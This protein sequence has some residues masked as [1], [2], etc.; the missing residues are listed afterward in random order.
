MKLRAK[1]SSII[2]FLVIV[3]GFL[4]V[5]A[6]LSQAESQALKNVKN[7]FESLANVE[8]LNIE[9]V[10]TDYKNRLKGISS[11]TAFR[12]N[13]SS[14]HAT[15]DTDYLVSVE[16]ILNDAMEPFYDLQKAVVLSDK[17]ILASINIEPDEINNLLALFGFQE[18]VTYSPLEKLIYIR[19][20]IILDDE[21]LGEVILGFDDTV[22]INSIQNYEGLG[23]TGEIL[24]GYKND[25]G[26]AAFIHERRFE[27]NVLTS[28][29]INM[30]STNVPMVQALLKNEDI[31]FDSIDYRGQPVV[32]ATRYIDSADWGIV[33]KIDKDEL[34]QDI[35]DFTIFIISIYAIV[36]VFVIFTS[37]FLTRYLTN[38]IAELNKVAEDIAKGNLKA[39]FPSAVLEKQD[40]IG[41]LGRTMKMMLR[42]I[43]EDSETLEKRV[44]D[45]TRQLNKEKKK[46]E[47]HANNLEKFK[48]AMDS[49]SEQVVI[50]DAKGTVLYANQAV[51]HMMNKALDKIIGHSSKELWGEKNSKHFYKKLWNHVH[52]KKAIFVDEIKFGKKKD[53]R[54]YKLSVAPVLDDENKIEYFV[55]VY[56][57]ITREKNIDRMKTEFISL[58]SHQLRTP[59]SA[60]NWITEMLLENDSGKLN[61]KQREQI[62]DIEK[63]NQRMIDLVNSLLNISRIESGRIIVDPIETDLSELIKGVLTELKPALESKG[64]KCV[65]SI[66]Q[67]IKSVKL[68]QQ[69]IHEVYKNFISN[70]IKYTPDGG[71]ITIMVSV[72][73]NEII[74]QITDNGLGIP[75]KEQHR[76]FGKFF[77]A[78]NIQSIATEGSGLGLYLVKAIV[79]SSH[80]KV[81][82]RSEE[83]KG[84]S[85]FFSLPKSGM[86][87]KKGEV[88]LS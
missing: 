72:K 58:A 81:W 19:G 63:A 12:R 75:E 27:S 36:F 82:F 2:Y 42:N 56:R 85:F 5:L 48:L 57:D 16:K 70:A 76:I 17:K 37:I 38:P 11:R 41:L 34:N 1:L 6:T 15:G 22:I 10:L 78:D 67:H 52:K 62:E 33:V 66:S 28:N 32:A 39:R 80:G 73:N 83:N 49:T 40:E 87:K 50:S 79:E 3:P 45:R 9:N 14:Y 13:I 4:M 31:L 68:D 24:V 8:K 61:K 55:S 43:R 84:T 60:V 88:K 26:E 29:V 20:E 51:A 77:R 18:D 46:S 54:S 7:Q 35:Y 64:H 21:L 65:T 69:L 44:K 74:S 59:L 47:Q 53:T 25:Y 23:E 30:T 71:E 86:K